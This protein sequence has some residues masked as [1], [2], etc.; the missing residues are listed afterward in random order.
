MWHT[1]FHHSATASTP[2]IAPTNRAEHTCIPDSATSHPHD[3]VPTEPK[4]IPLSMDMSTGSSAS[5]INDTSSRPESPSTPATDP[6][7]DDAPE[8]SKETSHKPSSSQDR[9]ASTQLLAPHSNDFKKLLLGVG[10]LRTETIEKVCCGGGCCFLDALPDDPGSKSQLPVILPDN[11]AFRSLQLKLG[12]LSLDSVLTKLVDP[13]TETVSF[14]PLQNLDSPQVAMPLASHSDRPFMAHPKSSDTHILITSQ[15]TDTP[16][17]ISSAQPAQ[18]YPQSTVYTHPPQFVTPHPPYEVYSAKVHHAR[19]L[20]RLG[21]EKRT[22]HFDL[23]VTDY[24]E[25]GGNVDFVV[26]GAIGVCAPN[27]NEMVDDIFDIL[28]V[29]KFVRD[30]PVKLITDGGRWPTIWGE[31]DKREL[32]TT[33]RELLTWCSDLQSYPPTKTLFRLLAEYADDPN[34]KKILMYL[35]SAQGQA[36][37]CDIRTGPHLT[38]TQLL[39]AFPSSKPPLTHLLSVLR[40]LMPRFYSLSQDPQISYLRESRRRIIE[41]AVTVHETPNWRGG[42][43][44]GVGSGFLER[45]AQKIITARANGIDPADLNIRV[46]MFRGLMANPLAR[47]FITDGPSLLIGAG[48]GVAPFRGFIQRRLRAANCVNKIYLLQGVRDKLLDELYSGEWGV[49]EDQVKFVVQSRA[50]T[51]MHVQDEVRNQADLVWWIINALDGRVFVC[52]SANG[53]GE[54]VEAALV[55]V[56]M[57]KAQLN[58]EEAEAFWKGKKEGGQYIAVSGLPVPC[59]V[60]M[61]LANFCV[62]NVVRE[63]FVFIEMVAKCVQRL[64]SI[65]RLRQGV[66]G[67]RRDL[68]DK[69]SFTGMH[70]NARD[71]GKEGRWRLCSFFFFL[72]VGRINFSSGKTSPP[73]GGGSATV[74]VSASNG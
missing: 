46:P 57:D 18:S 44:T 52:G 64:R 21:A 38:I 12:S 74:Y 5:S 42:P 32:A 53:M 51:K 13:P 37:F 11:D 48:V 30:K 63:A 50:G 59:D 35:A 66:I 10:G 7:I 62:G 34:E 23:D 55:D 29:P 43:R 4:N 67:R 33:R 14:Q 61:R 27:S 3:P 56:V 58:R 36:A 68:G 65:K 31:E 40:T 20:T 47:E 8:Q 39:H 60:V 19:E 28:N 15:T 45:I 26:G 54:G 1:A 2:T 71:M 17:L 22:Y 49:E 6:Q 41:I 69:P 70:I 24:P 73:K 72:A 25:E 9:R 16:L